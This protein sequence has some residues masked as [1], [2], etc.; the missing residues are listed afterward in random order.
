GHGADDA[1][2]AE[3]AGA[4]KGDDLPVSTALLLWRRHL[5]IVATEL[6]RDDGPLGAECPATLAGAM[7]AWD[8]GD[9]RLVDHWGG[10]KLAALGMRGAFVGW[11]TLFAR[12][13]GP[14][15]GIRGGL[16]PVMAPMVG[17][18][19]GRRRSLFAIEAFLLGAVLPRAHDSGPGLAAASLFAVALCVGGLL[20]SRRPARL[21][22]LGD[23]KSLALRE[24]W[25]LATAGTT[26]A[27][28]VGAALLG[29]TDGLDPVGP[30]APAGPNRGVAPYAAPVAATAI[31][32]FV[33]WF[34]A[35]RVW[36]VAF[37]VANSTVVAAWV[38]IGGH[39]ATI[40]DWPGG[41]ALNVVGS[42][43]W[44]LVALALVTTLVGYNVDLAE[45][46]PS[47]SLETPDRAPPV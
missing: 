2:A 12:V 38:A 39:G 32:T 44:A 46:R 23:R 41:S 17:F 25:A 27:V 20:A 1:V 15:S 9:R 10:Q 47:T 21:A 3:L 37:T 6:R 16:A 24:G 42:F 34:W 22:V 31:A 35:R 11:K 28:L 18:V 40:A 14:L 45:F 29:F 36:R 7:A 4:R 43:W 26:A 30:P 5:E 13:G 19:L 8:E 33:T